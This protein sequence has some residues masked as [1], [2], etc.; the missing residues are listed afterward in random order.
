MISPADIRAAHDHMN[1][2]LPRYSVYVNGTYYYASSRRARF[3]RWV[4]TNVVGL[5]VSLYDHE[6]PGWLILQNSVE[7][8]SDMNATGRPYAPETAAGARTDDVGYSDVPP[9]RWSC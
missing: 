4:L 9:A 6:A 2:G 5:N 1:A 3:V 8:A 7:R